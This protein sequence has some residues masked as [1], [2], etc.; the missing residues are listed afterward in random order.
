M[1][2]GRGGES[3]VSLNQDVERYGKQQQGIEGCRQNLKAVVAIG[4]PAIG[5]ASGN[6]NGRQCDG[7]RGSIGQHV[8]GIRDES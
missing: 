3:S 5:R 7:E 8:R 2:F 4:S 1:D 6:A